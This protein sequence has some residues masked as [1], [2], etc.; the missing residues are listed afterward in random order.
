MS[1]HLNRLH[2][3]LLSTLHEKLRILPLHVRKQNR[4]LEDTWLVQRFKLTKKCT[5]ASRTD[6]RQL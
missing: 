3:A 4:G 2:T 5:Y 1:T 6:S